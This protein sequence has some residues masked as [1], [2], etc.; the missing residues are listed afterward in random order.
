MRAV[1][2]QWRQAN[3]PQTI[4][5]R[6]TRRPQYPRWNHGRLPPNPRIAGAGDH[7]RPAVAV[8]DFIARVD[9]GEV[10]SRRSYAAFRVALV[11][12]GRMTMAADHRPVRP[13]KR[14][15]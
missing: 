10:R 7:G 8:L 3:T 11:N 9:R 5:S 4:N 6:T 14:R 15:R 1:H 2:W 13:R 12:G